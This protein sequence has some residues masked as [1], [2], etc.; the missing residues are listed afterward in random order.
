MDGKKKLAEVLSLPH[1]TSKKWLKFTQLSS[2]IMFLRHIQL[3]K[4]G[5][6]LGENISKHTPLTCQNYVNN[7][8]T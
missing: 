2:K 4:N 8:P 3:G 1:H 7:L 6:M 5:Q